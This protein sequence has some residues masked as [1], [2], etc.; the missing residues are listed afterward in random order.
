[1]PSS[2]TPLLFAAREGNVP[3][4]DLLVDHG[5]DRAAQDADG[6]TA[7]LLAAIRDP[8]LRGATARPNPSVGGRGRRTC[9]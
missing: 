6:S 7:M 3:V 4:F 9:E 5:A 8:A 1:M 2:P